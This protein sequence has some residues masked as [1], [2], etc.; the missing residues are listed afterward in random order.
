MDCGSQ[1]PALRCY[2]GGAAFFCTLPRRSL[3]GT[4]RVSRLRKPE[5]ILRR[6]QEAWGLRRTARE[7]LS[8]VSLLE[9]SQA[10][11]AILSNEVV[12]VRALHQLQHRTLQESV[13]Y[14]KRACYTHL[15]SASPRPR[16]AGSRSS[17]SPRPSV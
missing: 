2:L 11:L 4:G 15:I 1:T 7:I 10:I 5:P 6:L 9:E 8:S 14:S 3:S 17:R 12:R 16:A 13:W